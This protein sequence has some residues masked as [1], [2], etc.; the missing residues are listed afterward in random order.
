MTDHANVDDND[1][2][3]LTAL[4]RLAS[5]V[6]GSAEIILFTLFAQLI[7]QSADPLGSEISQGAA[8][9]LILPLVL[10]TL[11]GLLLAW[12]GHAPRAALALVLLALP[13][14][15]ALWVKT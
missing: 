14:V 3:R 13:L 7:L 8:L 9:L 15:A 2:A 11:P 1:D 5:L 12:L 10:L 6:I 4:L